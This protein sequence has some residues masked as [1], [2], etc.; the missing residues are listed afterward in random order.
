[1]QRFSDLKGGITKCSNAVKQIDQYT[2][3]QRLLEYTGYMFR[4]VNRSSSGLQ[5]RKSQVPF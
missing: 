5:Q 1:M 3:A 2:S 4:P